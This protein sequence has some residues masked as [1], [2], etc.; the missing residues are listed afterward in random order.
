MAS[1][2]TTDQQLGGLSVPACT[3]VQLHRL[4]VLLLV[5]QHGGV[6][7]QVDA[8]IPLSSWHTLRCWLLYLVPGHLLACQGAWRCAALQH[9]ACISRQ[10]LAC[11]ALLQPRCPT[12]LAMR[13][14]TCGKSCCCASATAW[15]HWLSSTQQ[16]TA[17]LGW[18][19]RVKASTASAH[20]P[21]DWNL[22]AAGYSGEISVAG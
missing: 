13:P 12:H 20:S 8:C 22:H 18:P 19:A 21:T 15:S 4:Q 7:A 14:S 3:P 2:S 16:S 17:R 5:Q 11:S 6:P 9:A 1:G 10:G